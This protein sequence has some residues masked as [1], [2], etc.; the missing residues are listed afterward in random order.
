MAKQKWT[1]PRTIP[2]LMAIGG[3]VA[4]IAAFVLSIEKVAILKDPAFVPSCNINPILS[5]GSVMITDQAEAFGF[6]N[7]FLGIAGFAV[8]TAIGIALLAGGVFKRWFWLAVQAGL[9]FAVIFI[10]WLAFQSIYRIGALCPYCMVVWSM[11]IPLFWYVTLYNLRAGHIT[12][13]KPLKKAGKFVQKHHGDILLVWFLVIIG[14]IV[15]HFWYYWK[16]II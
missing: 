2:W 13:P 1:L 6:P 11:T 9:L 14:A 5:C 8:V 16:T 3:F 15:E 10:H 4:F 12:T 7:P